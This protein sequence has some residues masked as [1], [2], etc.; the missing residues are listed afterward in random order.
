MRELSNTIGQL[1]AREQELLTKLKL[2]VCYKVPTIFPVWPS[3]CHQIKKLD[4]VIYAPETLLYF[5]L[6]QKNKLVEHN[7]SRLN[8]S[9]LRGYFKTNSCY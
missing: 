6:A 4:H 1:Q 9:A 2:K 5:H 3:T 8:H 7:N